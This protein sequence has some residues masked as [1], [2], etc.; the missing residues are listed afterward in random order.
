MNRLLIFM[1]LTGVLFFFC[2][3]AFSNNGFDI[4]GDTLTFE[5][6]ARADN[7]TIEYELVIFDPG[8]HNWFNRVRQ[9][10]WFYSD[11]Y[12]TNWNTQ[13]VSQWNY[14]YQSSSGDCK[15][16]VYIDYDP[17]IDYGKELNHKLFYYFRYM[18]EVCGLFTV[19][20]GRW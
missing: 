6:D 5:T 11:S 14:L 17:K 19:T 7:D 4:P 13:L 2:G 12:L 20:P 1:V 8:F 3:S 18:H 10:E 9:P 15:P 16:G